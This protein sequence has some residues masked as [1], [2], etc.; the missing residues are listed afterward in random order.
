MK[1]MKFT[2]SDDAIGTK[3]QICNQL[4]KSDFKFKH[5]NEK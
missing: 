3:Q 4:A 1:G 5:G 2:L